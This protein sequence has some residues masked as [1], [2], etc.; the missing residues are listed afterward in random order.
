MT[1]GAGKTVRKIVVE[2]QVGQDRMAATDDPIFLG[3]RGPA[4][5]EFRL[6]APRG[7]AWRRGAKE[8]LVLGGADDPES[9][10][11][12]PELNDPG[13]PALP[14]DQVSGVYLR[15]GLEPIPNVRGIAEMDDRLELEV[16]EVT[17][18]LEDGE[19]RRFAR[20]GP[21]WLGLICGLS[22]DLAPADGAG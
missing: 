4:G 7:R 20:R 2:V 13:A 12:H 17:L 15:K 11:A 5:R 18:H 22:V 14:A 6:A 9:N 19:T 21:V 1:S 10:V 3:L 16:V 8:H